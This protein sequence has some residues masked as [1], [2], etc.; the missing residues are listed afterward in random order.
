M[1]KK[2][3]CWE[4]MECGREPGGA[5]APEMGPC[6]AATERKVNG[7]N[8]GNYAGRACWAITGTL[9]EGE[10]SGKFTTKICN[11]LVCDFYQQ[12]C[13]EQDKEFKGTA[14]ILGMLKQ[15]KNHKS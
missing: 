5:K 7:I 4:W 15:K 8:D 3:N 14:I 6:P 10:M 9:C 13:Q 1:I 12:V 2:L 11:C